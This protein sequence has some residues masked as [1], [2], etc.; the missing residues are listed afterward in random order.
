MVTFVVNQTYNI[1]YSYSLSFFLKE[2]MKNPAGQ[3]IRTFAATETSLNIELCRR[4]LTE[5]FSDSSQLVSLYKMS[6]VSLYLIGM[7]DF[8]VETKSERFNAFPSEP[9]FENFTPSV[10]RLRQ[11]NLN[12]NACCSR[13]SQNSTRDK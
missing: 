9:Q 3:T 1:Y 4:L 7:Y 11:R 12:F 10:R 8:Q 13:D 6:Q 5:V 2:A